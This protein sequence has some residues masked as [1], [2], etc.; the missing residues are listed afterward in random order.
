[1]NT[2]PPSILQTICTRYPAYR[3]FLS[4]LVPTNVSLKD[5]ATLPEQNILSKLDVLYIYGLGSGKICQLLEPWL[6][7][8]IERHL[9]FIEDDFTCVANF[10]VSSH[11]RAIENPRIHIRYVFDP[12][13]LEEFCTQCSSEFPIRYISILSNKSGKDI[14][15]ERMKLLLFKYT[16]MQQASMAECIL[17]PKLLRNVYKNIHF[18][19][20]ITLGTSLK[21]QCKNIP[22]VIC[23]G[24]PSLEACISDLGKLEHSALIFA[25]G[26][27]ITALTQ[28]NIQPHICIAADPNQMEW[29]QLREM[30]AFTAP[31]CFV[32]R[33]FSPI[34]ALHNGP[35]VYLQMLSSGKIES[36]IEETLEFSKE[37]LWDVIHPEAN[38]VTTLAIAYAS[39]LGC[40]P[41]YLCGV[42]LAYTSGL[43]YAD[44]VITNNTILTKDS[45][46]GSTIIYQKGMLGEDIATASK[47]TIEASWISQ[48]AQNHNEIKLYRASL[49][50]LPI[51]GTSFQPLST[52]FSCPKKD[53]EGMFFS[54]IQRKKKDYSVKKIKESVVTIQKSAQR[55]HRLCQKIVNALQDNAKTPEYEPISVTLA[56]LDLQQE[57]IYQ[58]VF[59]DFHERLTFFFSTI[60]PE[61]TANALQYIIWKNI[62]QNLEECVDV[63][64]STNV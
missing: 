7:N 12:L 17:Y 34:H 32:P 43:L 56:I 63:F 60:Y 61:H 18:V 5:I 27:G 8:K 15:F 4:E 58:K 24:G 55:S 62:E 13:S 64:S 29:N 16:T 3:L 38:S 39:F 23:G 25:G 21:G 37:Y 10:L 14:F 40:N 35:L 44:K 9:I 45:D 2:I 19:P 30:N 57:E 49:Q 59:M 22:A 42:D 46:V 54:L 47:W 1:M 51:Q 52:L 26:S 50:G 6:K 20:E 36:M 31:M 53:L 48:F 41:L 28:Q 33:V 11:A